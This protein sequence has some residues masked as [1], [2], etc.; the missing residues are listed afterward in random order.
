M[1]PWQS[2]PCC[3]RAQVSGRQTDIRSSPTRS[4]ASA[5]ILAQIRKSTW[6]QAHKLR[7]Y[8][9]CPC[10]EHLATQEG[11]QHVSS[12]HLSLTQRKRQACLVS[13]D[14][15]AGLAQT[16]HSA[17]FEEDSSASTSKGIPA[18]DCGS[19]LSGRNSVEDPH[20]AS[21]PSD[22]NVPTMVKL[23]RSHQC[24]VRRSCK[25]QSSDTAPEG[26]V[27]ACHDPEKPPGSHQQQAA[28]KPN[29]VGPS[30]M[31]SHGGCITEDT[32]VTQALRRCGTVSVP[33]HH[34]FAQ[35]SLTWPCCQACTFY[36]GTLSVSTWMAASKR[37][38]ARESNTLLTL[39][40]SHG[41]HCSSPTVWGIALWR[42]RTQNR[43]PI[44]P[45]HALSHSEA[46]C[47]SAVPNIHIK[48]MTF[49][50]W[51]R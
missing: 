12:F 49:I 51:G 11:A 19:R 34:G 1:S 4:C 31:G 39:K 48:H 6:Q 17:T 3:P 38:R 2:H 30:L 37:P 20:F 27:R 24:N 7:K 28:C 5:H 41:S 32:H 10:T 9:G 43:W 42:N 29:F 23:C 21:S 13:R 8:E 47:S 22:A 14:D 16:R 35:A 25:V 15:G 26:G 36:A 44:W 46:W 18:K 50:E 33:Y 40:S 45:Y